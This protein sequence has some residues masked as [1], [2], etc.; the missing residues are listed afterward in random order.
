MLIG[1]VSQSV[2]RRDRAPDAVHAQ[3]DEYA[4]GCWP[5]LHDLADAQI[6]ELFVSHGAALPVSA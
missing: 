3:I 2:E 6:G 1:G 4:Y 5:S